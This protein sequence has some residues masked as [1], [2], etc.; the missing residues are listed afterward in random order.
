[1]TLS[2]MIRKKCLEEKLIEQEAA[3]TFHER[4][5]YKRFWRKRIGSTPAWRIGGDAVFLCGLLVF[6][7]D[8]LNIIVEK[9]PEEYMG[10]AGKTCYNIECKFLQSELEGLSMFLG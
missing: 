1:M 4:R 5:E 8:V 6:W 3:G 2:F 9:T 10:V 7:A